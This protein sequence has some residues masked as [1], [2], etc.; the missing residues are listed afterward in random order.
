MDKKAFYLI[1]GLILI[2]FVFTML[3]TYFRPVSAGDVNFDDFP[4]ELGQWRG[5][6]ENISQTVIDLLNPMDITSISYV[7]NDGVSIHLFFD[8]FSSDASFGGP[9]SPR[10]CVPGSGWIIE[11]TFEKD[12]ELD[13]RIIHSGVFELRFEK[14]F[15][16]MEFWYVTHFGETANDY[17]FKLYELLS[18]LTFS[19]RDVAFIRFVTSNDPRSLKALK[20]FQT[21]VVPE[22][23]KQ[24]PF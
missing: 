22:I 21:L 15:S 4:L 12:I 8:Y 14:S 11:N 17:K 13:G 24:L 16:V 18:A 6:K 7:N 3:L 10:N 23:Y 1:I 19:P 20:E 5:K 2:V 9:H